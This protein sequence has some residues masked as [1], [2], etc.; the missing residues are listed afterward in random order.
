MKKIIIIC[1]GQS[2]EA[3]CNQILKKHFA[4]LD[5][6][7]ENTLILYSGGGIVKWKHLKAQI[8][9]YHISAPEAFTTTF[10]D[11]YGLES[12]HKFPKWSDAQ[13]E[14]DKVERM[15]VLENAMQND[16]EMRFKDKFIPHIQLHEFEALVFSDF[17]CF[18]SL[19]E[20]NELDSEQLNVLC[21]QNPET[22]NNGTATAPSKR[23]KRH[24]PAYDKVNDGVE[25]LKLIGLN[26]IRS[27]CLHFNDWITKL[28]RI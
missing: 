19:Y 27:K 17:S 4:E 13:R 6:E 12:H 25:L 23:L 22:I 10:I 18:E 24:I 3:F 2:E 7:I 21:Q 9:L 20:S 28:E 15:L 16:I 8:E 14:T 5:I 11:Y 1:E 26:K